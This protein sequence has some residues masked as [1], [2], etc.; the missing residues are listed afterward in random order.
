MTSPSVCSQMLA[1]CRMWFMQKYSFF[2]YTAAQ[3]VISLVSKLIQR[4]K[5]TPEHCL[6]C[7]KLTA[8]LGLEVGISLNNLK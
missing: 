2:L 6:P 4:Y 1:K 7:R 3:V 5:Q 8:G